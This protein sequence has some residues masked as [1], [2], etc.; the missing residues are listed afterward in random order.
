[1]RKNN[2]YKYVLFALALLP[3]AYILLCTFRKGEFDITTFNNQFNSVVEYTF[4]S[5]IKTILYENV[6]NGGYSVWVDFVFNY[7]CYF[8]VVLIFDLFFNAIFV[9]IRI[10]RNLIER[11]CFEK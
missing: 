6:F 8:F 3:I 11:L 9:F 1:M 5:D 7:L 4:I 10:L 2:I